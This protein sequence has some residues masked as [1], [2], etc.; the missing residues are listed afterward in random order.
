V[1]LCTLLFNWLT[2]SRLTRVIVDKLAIIVEAVIL[3][4]QMGA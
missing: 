2:L 3:G 1:V 4:R